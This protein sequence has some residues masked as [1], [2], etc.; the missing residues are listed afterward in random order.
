MILVTL[1]TFLEKQSFHYWTEI[2]IFCN[3]FLI[4]P[5]I[6]LCWYSPR[7]PSPFPSPHNLFL[8]HMHTGEKVG[9]WKLSEAFSSAYLVVMGIRNI[10]LYAFMEENRPIFVYT[11]TESYICIWDN[12]SILLN[13]D[14]PSWCIIN[15]YECSQSKSIYT[16]IQIDKWNITCITHLCISCNMSECVS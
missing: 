13:V 11:C 2:W 10:N 3:F 4:F 15:M 8:A 16:C 5:S 6:S 14:L 7:H 1:K 12:G 9:R